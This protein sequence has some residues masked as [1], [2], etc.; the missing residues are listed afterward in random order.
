MVA[1]RAN[2]STS[3]CPFSSHVREVDGLSGWHGNEKPSPD[4]TLRS[5]GEV[6]KSG[7]PAAVW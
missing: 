4:V 6:R 2:L 3:N 7:G 1:M 5:T